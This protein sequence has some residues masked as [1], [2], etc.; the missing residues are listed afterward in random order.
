MSADLYTELTIRGEKEELFAM[1]KVLRDCETIKKKQYQE[2][3]D[4]G[5]LDGV[6]VEGDAFPDHFYLEKAIDEE[7]LEYLNKKEKKADT[8]KTRANACR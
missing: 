5:Y 7:L 8:N 2:K 3:R 4:C 6:Y 1:L